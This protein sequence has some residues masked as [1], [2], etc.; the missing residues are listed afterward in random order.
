[1]VTDDTPVSAGNLKAYHETLT[2]G[3][4]S[5]TWCTPSAQST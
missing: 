5:L 3:G 4:S 1:M 2:G